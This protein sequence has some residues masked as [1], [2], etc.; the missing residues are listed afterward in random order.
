MRLTR[1]RFLPLPLAV[2]VTACAAPTS[3]APGAGPGR[4]ISVEGGSYTRA[5]A[6]ELKAMLDK[7][8]FL[9]VNVRIPNDG[10]IPG[11]DAHIPYDAVASHLDKLPS[12]KAARVFIYCRSGNTS[13][14]A[15][16]ALVK[17][18][19]TGVW[20]LDGGIGAWKAAGYP[21]LA[22]GQ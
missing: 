16:Q 2:L 22:W 10:I 11:T 15:A 20:E 5:T 21:T 12:D 18:G 9:L 3:A 8:D 7:K 17:L 1:R 19:F 14:I 13:Q 4:R 6:A